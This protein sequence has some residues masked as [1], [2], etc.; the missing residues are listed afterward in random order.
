MLISGLTYFIT[1]SHKNSGKLSIAPLLP[2]SFSPVHM[3]WHM[4]NVHYGN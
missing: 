4:E 1:I 3:P 2:E